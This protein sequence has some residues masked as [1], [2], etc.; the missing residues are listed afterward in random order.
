MKTCRV[1]VQQEP[2][3]QIEAVILDQEVSP[4]GEDNALRL[5]CRW[6]LR[7]YLYDQQH[8]KSLDVL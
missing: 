2:P 3:V 7:A 5:L 6:A 8:D 1:D 4:E